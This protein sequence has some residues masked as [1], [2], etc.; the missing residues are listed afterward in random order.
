MSPTAHKRP[1]IHRNLVPGNVLVRRADRVAKLGDLMQAKALEG[2]LA[3]Q[4]TRPGQVIGNLAYVP[5]ECMEN[6]ANADIRS[7]LYGLGSMVYAVLTGHP[8]FEGASVAD[9]FIKI[10]AGEPT[11]PKK[12]Q[13]NVPEHFESAILR[14]LAKKPD[15]RFQTTVDLLETLENIANFQGLVG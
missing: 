7:D 5:P 3:V 1:I 9:L 14:M 11:P 8:P 4:L 6:S 10:R 2:S 12:Y 13:P 15:E